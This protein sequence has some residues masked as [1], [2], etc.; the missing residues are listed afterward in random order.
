MTGN[1][2][3]VTD[4]P[5]TMSSNST[6]PSNSNNGI[7]LQ[8][9]G[10]KQTIW[11]RDIDT[12][13]VEE[14]KWQRPPFLSKVSSNDNNNK[15]SNINININNNNN[16]NKEKS[17]DILR[18]DVT[19]NTGK[20]I[21]CNRW[22]GREYEKNKNNNNNFDRCSI[23]DNGVN[24][25]IVG[26]GH[27]V[28]IVEVA[29]HL[30]KTTMDNLDDDDDDDDDD[31]DDDIDDV[32]DNN[33]NDVADDNDDGDSLA[34]M[35]TLSDNVSIWIDGEKHWISG[36]DGKTTCA[37]L[38]CALLNYQS[39]QQ[40]MFRDTDENDDEDVN[41]RN[42]NRVEQVHLAEQTQLRIVEAFKATHYQYVNHITANNKGQYSKQLQTVQCI[43]KNG[44]INNINTT[45]TNN[46]YCGNKPNKFSFND[47]NDDENDN[48]N[49]VIN[50][51]MSINTKEDCKV[52][53]ST[54]VTAEISATKTA[55]ATAIITNTN[56][57]TNINM[58]ANTNT[59]TNTN[60]N[61]N[62]NTTNTEFAMGYI[63][64]RGITSIQLATEYVIVKQHRHCEEYLDGSTKVFDVLPPR[65]AP[66]KKEC[67]LLLRRLG[68][69]PAH[70]NT[71]PQFSSLISTDKDSGM[72]SPAG[73]ARSAKF[74]RRKHKSS[75]WLAYG[76]TLHPKLSRCSANER[77]MKIIL[78]QDETIQRQLSL[79]REKERQIAKIEEEKHRKRERELG[80]NYLLETYLNGL[81]EAECEPEIV[82]GEEIFI[83]EP[84]QRYTANNT[85]AH[86]EALKVAGAIT[87]VSGGTGS[88]AG[89]G[90]GAG[91]GA[92][93]GM[94]RIKETKKEKKKKRHK[95]KVD[96]QKRHKDENHK[97]FANTAKDFFAL[98][99]STIAT[100]TAP[101][102]QKDK[103]S[104]TEKFTKHI[105][106]VDAVNTGY[107]ANET[108]GEETEMQIFWLEKVYTLN[109]Q[110]QKEEELSAKLHAKIRKY[111]LKRAY[112]TQ[113]EV[114]L[115]IE[116]LDNNLALQC[117]DI[118]KVEANLMETNE[119][120]QKK[121]SLLERLSQEY[122][123][124]QQQKHE[125]E[126]N[127][128]QT[129]EE[130]KKMDE[131]EKFSEL[132]RIAL[133]N[134]KANR[135]EIE[136]L[137]KL[138]VKPS[139]ELQAAA[140]KPSSREPFKQQLDTDINT[141]NT[142][143]VRANEVQQ[144]NIRNSCGQPQQYPQSQPKPQFQP[145]TSPLRQ[146][147][148]QQEQQQHQHQQEQKRQTQLHN[149][150]ITQ[151]N[152][153]N[154]VTAIRN[155]NSNI[156]D[157]NK[158]TNNNSNSNN[159]NAI[160]E[161]SSSLTATTTH[162]AYTQALDPESTI[163]TTTTTTATV[164]GATSATTHSM[165]VDKNMLSSLHV[166]NAKT[167]K[168]QMFNSQ[169]TAA[170]YVQQQQLQQPQ[171]HQQQQQQQQ[172]Q[173]KTPTCL[174]ITTSTNT[175]TTRPIVSQ[176]VPAL[177]KQPANTS[178]MMAMNT[179]DISQLG[180]LV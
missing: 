115:E 6:A 120:L 78:A 24:D 160:N 35:E 88:G 151:I 10:K 112:Q 49:N 40:Q 150:P 73:S 50:Q 167:I 18:D 179:I 56:T 102:M 33:N 67:E 54:D 69:A 168:K 109:K 141:N 13:Q 97:K 59:N 130:L 133:N 22:T 100:A 63:L 169:T 60:I 94:E 3:N 8:S 136:K 55:T 48:P 157:T 9:H 156:S 34:S 31:V 158:L 153:N 159:I 147:Q 14:Q 70:I 161:I 68:P 178:C 92:G 74:R 52:T 29:E 119:V 135:T 89:N 15:K 17:N 32:D 140:D 2:N 65:D 1:S 53:S 121:L 101:A 41:I 83:D 36:V 23:D 91:T 173:V 87:G 129:N 45:T 148:Q 64:P 134:L 81:N 62:A 128:M 90:T 47:D 7:N 111:Q 72:G 105:T 5:N 71:T 138:L 118:R 116:K 117:S 37:D 166:Q 82:D 131:I 57:N 75:Q 103:G 11:Y 137:Q 96:D 126:N 43:A 176:L 171:Q 19:Q 93:T 155:H 114:Q 154:N 124:C 177:V 77:L 108:V 58:N 76:N 146:P 27:N 143:E 127:A 38:I 170:N 174:S 46:N 144:L 85:K 132:P 152:Q 123:R 106:N 26:D 79:L 80:K 21:Q 145:L 84:Y 175:T 104:D 4:T 149:Y 172:Q 139:L 42:D 99:V 51:S 98:P 107:L 125:N 95:D 30:R 44:I 61:I 86:P 163:T 12:A 165:F 162:V 180:T 25:V 122:L 39:G 20:D 164:V 28:V 113:K 66:H 110:L 16:N 142:L